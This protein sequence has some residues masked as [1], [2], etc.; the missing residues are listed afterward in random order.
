MVWPDRPITLVQRRRLR[1]SAAI[2]VQAALAEKCAD[3]EVRER[4]VFG[5]ADREVSDGVLAM[6]GLDRA[7]VVPKTS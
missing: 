4:L 7:Q 2:T 6:L 1:A 3:G 5:I